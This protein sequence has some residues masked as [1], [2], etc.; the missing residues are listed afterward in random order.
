MK[1]ALSRKTEAVRQACRKAHA[2]D[3]FVSSPYPREIDM[4]FPIV[5]PVFFFSV[6]PHFKYFLGSSLNFLIQGLQQNS[7]FFPS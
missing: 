4:D 1:K 6:K 5:A 3:R 2:K 7:I